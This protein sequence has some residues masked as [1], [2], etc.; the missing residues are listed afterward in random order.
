MAAILKNQVANVIFQIIGPRGI[1]TPNLVLVS[2][3]ERFPPLSAPLSELNLSAVPPV[4][5]C[6]EGEQQW[7]KPRTLVIIIF[8]VVVKYVFTN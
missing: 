3:C 6:T 2:T 1:T 7:H 5:S 4:L 8:V